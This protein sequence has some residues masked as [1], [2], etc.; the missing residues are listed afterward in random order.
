[1]MQHDDSNAAWW[2]FLG[3]C[4]AYIYQESN[5]RGSRSY[6]GL[7]ISSE[8]IA[9]S[10]NIISLH[11]K[12]LCETKTAYEEKVQKKL[13]RHTLAPRFILSL[14]PLFLKVGC[15]HSCVSV[16]RI[17]KKNWHSR[18]DFTQKTKHISNW[19]AC[20]SIQIIQIITR[21]EMLNKL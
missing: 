11:A 5:K 14:T 12:V 8:N 18:S 16:E 21:T 15:A 1:M 3:Y 7:A 4:I 13:H 2:R 6:C 17:T 10:H 9:N 20:N 19:F